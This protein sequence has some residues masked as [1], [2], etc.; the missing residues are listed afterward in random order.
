MSRASAERPWT[1][2]TLHFVGIGGAGMSGLALIASSAGRERH[3]L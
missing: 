1:G 2:Q 3:R